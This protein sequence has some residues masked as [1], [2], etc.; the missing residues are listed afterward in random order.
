MAEPVADHLWY[1]DA[2]IYQLH[3]KAFKD[4]NNDGI[5]DFKGLIE[6]LDY[7]AELG[8]NTLWLL[9][10]YPSPMRDDGYDIAEYTGIHSD[11][12]TRK[13]FRN[14]MRE[15]HRRNLRV[16][17]E[18]VIN[19]TSD[20]H[21]WFQAARKAPADSKKRD[22]YVWSKTNQK[23]SGTRIIFTD[24]E[25][26]N[27]TWDDEAQ[28][29]YWHRFFHHQPDLNHNNP[30]VVKAVIRLMR[31][32]LDMGVDGLRLDAIPY[33]CVREGTSN[34]NLPETH[35]VLKYMRSV[36]DDHYQDRVLLA[37][38]NQWPEDA[39]AYYGDGDECHMAYH[40]PLMPRIYM[41]VAQE[42]RHPIVEIMQQTPSIPDSCQWAIFLRNHDEL[43]L[44]M[45]TDRE[46][47]YM[48][49]RYATDP[50]M[51]INV[52]IR[53]RLAPLMDNDQDKIK[54]MNSVLMSMP[55]SPIVYYGD[56][57]GMGDNFFLGDRNGVRTPMQWSPDRNAGFSRADPQFLYLP[58]IMDPVYGYEAVNVEAHKRKPSSLLNWMKRL[59][60]IRRAHATFGRGSLEFLQPGNRKILAYVREYGD[61]CVLCV[62]NLA[63]SAQ[64]VELDLSRF[65]GSVPIEMLGR[66][67]FP[68]IG[69]LPYLLTLPG[70]GFYWFDLTSGAEA[71]PWHEEALPP[72]ELPTLVFFAGW[73]SF[74]PAEVE[75][76][77]KMLAENLRLQLERTILPDFL[78]AQRWY[79]EKG[80]L[81]Q[82]VDISDMLL[83]PA[84][85]GEWLWMWVNACFGD[86]S[87]QAYLLPL[88]MAWG[89]P[90]DEAVR[91]LLPSALARIRQQA[92][93]GIV[94]DAVADESFF[95]AIVRAVQTGASVTG[96]SG[97]LRFCATRACAELVDD[98]PLSGLGKSW[99]GGSNSTVILGDRL[100]LKLYRRVHQGIN[101]ELE[102][103]RFLTDVVHYPNIAPLAG[104]VEFEHSNGATSTLGLVQAHVPNQGDGWTFT[105]DYLERFFE[106]CLTRPEGVPPDG[107]E[108]HGQY[109]WMAEILG[110]RTGELHSALAQQTG[111]PD[112]EPES[113]EPQDLKAWS[114]RVADD[115]HGTLLELE[116]QIDNIKPAWQPLATEIQRNK[117]R[118]LARVDSLVPESASAMK[119]RYHGDF[120]LGQVL[121]NANDVVIIDFEGEPA[122]LPTERRLKHCP[123]RDVAGMLRSFNYATGV[124]LAN[125]SAARPANYQELLSYAREW[126]TVAVEAFLAG[127]RR[128]VQGCA[129]WPG[130]DAVAGQLIELFE[131]EKALYELRYELGNRVDWVN[132]PLE[133]L[134]KLL[135]AAPGQLESHL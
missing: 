14:F 128:G 77:R 98:A 54:L 36:V 103:S 46:R 65:R 49:E 94:Y 53:R 75:P 79:A 58:P 32:W 39:Q 109:R 16:I 41:A 67:A 70:H 120:H 22:F 6:Q 23:F 113:I 96:P 112:F 87:R 50:R 29:Y 69:D 18:L 90:E 106:D 89:E 123:L 8:V 129:S 11:Y 111:D 19:H 12:G 61:D 86:S 127:Y 5:G 44:E 122:R 31:F 134:L 15:A 102:M 43:T 30:E 131:L 115:V 52:G 48:Y 7:I 57:I 124:A 108:R 1:K 114:D 81:L 34:E 93:A 21:P 118:L 4:S 92:R 38:A 42:E 59:I 66:T 20:Q 132:I 60:A 17:T 2:I 107:A 88:A 33:L 135:T 56:E 27:W 76:G 45:V 9:P 51:R 68:P 110:Q 121:L 104:S 78:Q 126:E 116:A 13:D 64:P 10:F 101:P 25:I 97:T 35:A 71:P 83:W 24:S 95:R 73:R 91:P 72:P 105:V 125:S 62:A 3:V 117:A 133:G 74:F 55:G 37:E 100:F 130:D 28:A 63:R 119:T 85:G 82:R 47:D 26:S 40:F 84:E 99:V 80:Q